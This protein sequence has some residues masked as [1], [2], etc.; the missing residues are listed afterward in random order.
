MKRYLPFLLIGGVLIAALL[1]GI[2]LTR[3]SPSP[4]AN[5]SSTIPSDLATRPLTVGNQQPR[6]VTPGAEPPHTTW[7]NESTVTLEEFGDYQCPPCGALHKEIKSIEPTF[8]KRVR[9]IFRNY[10]LPTIHENAVDAARA[11][12][13]AGMQN[14]F[15]QMHDY[16]Y[17][18]QTKWAKEKDVRK[19]FTD[20]ART[21]GLDTTRF[22][23]DLDTLQVASRIQQDVDRGESLGV[24][25]TPTIFLNGRELELKGPGDL[26]KALEAAVQ[27]SK[28]R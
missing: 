8:N 17:D 1:V 28:S 6:A 22:T 20:F 14:R 19:I 24:H 12:E 10:P 21:L 7:Q 4:A 26:Q 9:L 27:Q 3:L 18:N 2:G 23:H 5:N 15:W 16:L 25:G 13:A 11:A